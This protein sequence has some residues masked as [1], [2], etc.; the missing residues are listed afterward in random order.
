MS[1]TQLSVGETRMDTAHALN[2]L[3]NTVILVALCS[4]NIYAGVTL[5]RFQTSWAVIC[6]L[7]F[8]MRA[9]SPWSWLLA[10]AHSLTLLVSPCLE[11]FPFLCQF[12][13]WYITPNSYKRGSTI[14][15]LGLKPKNWCINVVS[16]ITSH[17]QEPTVGLGMIWADLLE[18]F[19]ANSHF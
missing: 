3:T 11:V 18:Y 15:C 1:G 2:E 13:L 8:S 16:N 9:P 14:W 7:Y 17:S 6:W 10:F 12:V 19:R 5:N 4:I